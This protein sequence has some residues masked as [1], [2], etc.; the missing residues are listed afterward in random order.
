M[1]VIEVF[2]NSNKKILETVVELNK[3]FLHS[4][5]D[6]ADDTRIRKGLQAMLT[7]NSSGH[8]FVLENENKQIVGFCYLNIGCGLQ[9][10]GDYIW[11]NGIYI[12]PE[13]RKKNY[14]SFLLQYLQDW[15]KKRGCVY[16]CC[17]RDTDNFLSKALF[18]RNGF[19]QDDSIWIQK[20]L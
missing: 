14:A 2:Q 20:W 13:F 11:L 12:I 16:F 6:T 8:I 3:A 9:S 4:L 1:K 17:V 19:E 5:G 10:G 18:E 15:A 7:P